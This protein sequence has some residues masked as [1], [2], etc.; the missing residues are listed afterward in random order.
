MHAAIFLRLI[1]KNTVPCNF[2]S[3]FVSAIQDE[4]PQVD[5]NRAIKEYDRSAAD[6]VHCKHSPCSLQ[7]DSIPLLVFVQFYPWIKFY[8]PMFL[9]W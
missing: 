4:N 5:H 1:N 2:I 7:P 8:F 3:Y 9:V 6:K